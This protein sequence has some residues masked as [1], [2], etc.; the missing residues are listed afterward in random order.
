VTRDSYN[1][2]HNNSSPLPTVHLK[3]IPIPVDEL[4]SSYLEGVASGSL[5]DK[6]CDVALCVILH[7]ADGGRLV[8]G[9]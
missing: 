2:P 3:Y 6:G 1:C 9:A 4:A 5:V 7:L 8:F